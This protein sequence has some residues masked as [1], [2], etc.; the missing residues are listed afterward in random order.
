MRL[1]ESI[2]Q[3]REVWN[4]AL[5]P[6]SSPDQVDERST[7]IVF[8]GRRL[9]LPGRRPVHT[10]A[11]P[12]LFVRNAELHVFLETQEL[13]EHGRIEAYSTTDLKN[14]RAHGPVFSPPFHVSYPQVFAHRDD[15]F[16]VPETSQAR[17]VALYRFEQFPCR[18]RRITALLEGDYC[19]ATLVRWH[20]RWWLFATTATGLEIHH[21]SDLS[22]PYAPHPRNPVAVSPKTMRCGG[23]FLHHGDDLFRVAQDGSSS[24]GANLNIL[25]VS[26]LTEKV[27]REEMVTDGIFQCRQDWNE[28]GGHHLSTASFL[29]REIAGIDGRQRDF[30]VNRLLSLLTRMGS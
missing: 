19:D 24:Y 7:F 5:V 29:G 9:R 10:F 28:R 30:R 21:S 23:P 17:E 26:A 15:I 12:F 22:G 25:R 16:M 2:I 4:A 14:F 6:F 20:E 3:P 13:G 8:S 27:Y 18:L 1:G 11:D